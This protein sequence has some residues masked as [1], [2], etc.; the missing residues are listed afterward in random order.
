VGGEPGAAREA[1]RDVV[2]A[3]KLHQPEVA[4]HRKR[5]PSKRRGGRIFMW[6]ADRIAE[7]DASI[8]VAGRI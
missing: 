8:G 4:L 3:R 1:Q 5:A 7:T 2:V 6:A